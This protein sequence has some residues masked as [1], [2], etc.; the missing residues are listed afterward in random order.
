MTTNYV[1][2]V[3]NYG[4]T[5]YAAT[6]SDGLSISTDDGA[7]FTYKTSADGLGDDFLWGVYRNG[8]TIYVATNYGLS[9]SLNQPTVTAVNPNSGS[10]LGGTPI[11]I[12]GT[13]L[14]GATDITVGGVACTVFSVTNSTTATCTTPAGTAGTA[15]VQV[16][17]PGGTNAANTLFTYVAPVA[18]APIPTV[19]EWMMLLMASLMAIFGIR[20]MRRK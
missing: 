9:I 1:W 14:T 17:T 10:T 20:R 13:N 4:S 7:T 8:T 2:G 6:L 12:T 3:F 15:S 5:V 16:T 19:S 18:A 11:T